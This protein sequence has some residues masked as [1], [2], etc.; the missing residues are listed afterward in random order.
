MKPNFTIFRILALAVALIA[1]GQTAWAEVFSGYCFD[2]YGNPSM[3]WEYDTESKKLTIKTTDDRNHTIADYDSSN[4]PPWDPYKSDITAI[5]LS[6]GVSGIGNDAF[7]GCSALSS[8]VL[9]ASVTRI[10]NNAFKGCSALAFVYCLRTSSPSKPEEDCFAGTSDALVFV[11]PA[12]AF[13]D[14]YDN[15]CWS[16]YRS[17]LRKGYTVQTDS[18]ITTSTPQNAPLVQEGETVSLSGGMHYVN[19]YSYDHNEPYSTSIGTGYQGFCWGI[20]LPAGSYTGNVITKVAVHDYLRMAKGTLTI[21]N[22]GEVA[23]SGDPVGSMEVSFTGSDCFVTFEFAEPLT[24]DPVKNVWVVFKNES[25][26]SYTASACKCPEDLKD[27]NGRWVSTDG[28]DWMDLKSVGF[29]LTFMIHAFIEDQ[30]M[31]YSFK[32]YSVKDADDGDVSVDETSGIFSFVM[33][34]K[35]VTVTATWTADLKAYEGTVSDVTGY[36]ATI[37]HGSLNYQLPAGAQAFTM[38]SD[39][40]LIRVGTDGSIIPA[41]QA[42]VIIADESALTGVADGRGTLNLTVTNSTADIHGTNILRGGPATV[43]GLSGTPHVLG[44]AVSPATFGFHPYEGTAIPAN[45]AYYVQ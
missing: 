20:M 17:K 25:G 41:G 7:S 11:V 29:D 39:H 24:V 30:T 27:P 19:M 40:H 12:D 9:P 44:F 31:N 3:M 38:D 18:D 33:P 16:G 10:G 4:L 34:A 13:D 36:W 42:V 37:Y 15:A 1:A 8:I 14:Y 23:P 22:D 45:K 26:E 6:M 2:T 28:S 5:H 35:N 21:Y 43:S 32:G